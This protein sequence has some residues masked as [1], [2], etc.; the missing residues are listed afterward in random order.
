MTTPKQITYKLVRYAHKHPETGLTVFEIPQ[1]PGYRR[2]SHSTK[3]ISESLSTTLYAVPLTLV[4]PYLFG[5]I[6]VDYSSRA[7]SPV[8]KHP[9]RGARTI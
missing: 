2:H 7:I 1:I 8:P 9:H 4:N 6:F 3:D 5:G